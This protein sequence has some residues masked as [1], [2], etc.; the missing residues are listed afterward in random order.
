MAKWITGL[1]RTNWS[2][3][4]FSRVCSDHFAPEAFD[5]RDA[6]VQLRDDAVPT[7]FPESSSVTASQDKHATVILTSDDS[8]N[9]YTSPI[10][11]NTSE[12][13]TGTADVLLKK[14][15][16]TYDGSVVQLVAL[17]NAD[18]IDMQL[19]ISSHTGDEMEVPH[20]DDD[21]NDVKPIASLINADQIVMS[22][23]NQ[24]LKKG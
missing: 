16:V 8:R 11:N 18:E 23:E 22:D 4:H 3:Q 9:D 19:D 13:L 17:E 24:R 6:S 5:W 20:L 21:D 12:T 2:P 15:D 1:K 10:Q 7:S 14:L